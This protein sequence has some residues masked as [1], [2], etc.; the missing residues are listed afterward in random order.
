[1][2]GSEAGPSLSSTSP[3]EQ[4][5]GHSSLRVI[6][7]LRRRHKGTKRRRKR[8]ERA[9]KRLQVA[10]ISRSIKANR[11]P[12]H[13]TRLS[14]RKQPSRN[15]NPTRPPARPLLL[16]RSLKRERRMNGPL[17]YSVP[18]AVKQ[19]HRLHSAAFTAFI[20]RLQGLAAG[21][22][23]VGVGGGSMGWGALVKTVQ[24]SRTQDGMGAA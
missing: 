2:S 14:I 10:Q 3:L 23:G 17:Y 21:G 16:S 24:P 5:S 15:E 19:Q 6:S 22:V 1:M 11:P 8:P 7:F 12:P 20:N 4:K 9:E 13:P 18:C